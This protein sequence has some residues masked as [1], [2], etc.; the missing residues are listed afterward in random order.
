MATEAEAGSSCLSYMLICPSLLPDVARSLRNSCWS[1]LPTYHP[2][3]FCLF[4]VLNH[5]MSSFNPKDEAQIPQALFHLTP[6][7]LSNFVFT[8]SYV[9]ILPF[10]PFV[11]EFDQVSQL[12]PMVS[13]LLC[14]LVCSCLHMLVL[15]ILCLSSVEFKYIFLK[16]LIK[17]L[18]FLFFQTV[19]TKD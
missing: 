6:S 1:S 11:S 7:S 4:S 18:F 19:L 13:G 17:Q 10:V 3:Y 16:S 9:F 15:L 12:L 8:L 2:K 5:P 14:L